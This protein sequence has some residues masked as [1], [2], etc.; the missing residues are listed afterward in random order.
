MLNQQEDRSLSIGS[1]VQFT[2]HSLGGWKPSPLGEAFRRLAVRFR[3]EHVSE[4]IAH[5]LLT[6]LSFRIYHEVPQ[7]G[8]AGPTSWRMRTSRVLAPPGRAGVQRDA[9]PEG[10]AMTLRFIVAVRDRVPV[11]E[12]APA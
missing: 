2:F 12:E 10:A 7:A 8:A 5:S 4:V 6:A 9:D 11:G 1:A 3:G